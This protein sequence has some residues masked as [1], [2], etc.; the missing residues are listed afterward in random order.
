MADE[1]RGR[2]DRSDKRA[3]DSKR[4]GSRAPR[5]GSQAPSGSKLPSNSK[6]PSGSKTP[7]A[8]KAP[9]NSSKSAGVLS[10]SSKT[11]RPSTS[12]GE[13]AMFH[14]SDDGRDDGRTSRST[15]S[16]SA[17]ASRRESS[18]VRRPSNAGEGLGDLA[19]RVGNMSVRDGSSGGSRA[20]A[21]S[22]SGSGND[23]S[24]SW[25]PK[26]PVSKAPVSRLLAGG[27]SDSGSSSAS[28][29][30][31]HGAGGGGGS[32]GDSSDSPWLPATYGAG[33]G[34][35]SGFFSSQ[36][37][38]QDIP[39]SSH[40]DPARRQIIVPSSRFP[41]SGH[42]DEYKPRAEASTAQSFDSWKDD[43]PPRKAWDAYKQREEDWQ[44]KGDKYY[45]E[46]NNTPEDRLNPAA[47]GRSYSPIG[48][49]LNPDQRESVQRP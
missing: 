29:P 8:S 47:T 15:N 6:H 20:D 17:S 45:Q 27:S 39:S 35:G 30:A 5:S 7:S 16:S 46:M 26:A 48:K 49:K 32:G 42:S 40:V 28:L 44:K 4:S 3:G 23:S 12:S 25:Q 24:D 22:G 1:R 36:A 19:R 10:S 43:A 33:S 31:A 34:S 37:S 38:G 41:G 14:M 2:S 13:R 21:S 9:P 11:R 18:R